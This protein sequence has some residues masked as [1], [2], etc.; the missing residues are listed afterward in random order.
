MKWKLWEIM[1]SLNFDQKFLGV[2]AANLYVH[3][4]LSTLMERNHLKIHNNFEFSFIEVFRLVFLQKF[5]IFV[6]FY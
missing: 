5:D 6:R 1:Q 4:T 3:G 2:K